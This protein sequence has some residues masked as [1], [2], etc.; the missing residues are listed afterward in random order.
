[1]LQA[2]SGLPLEVTTGDS[3]SSVVAVVRGTAPHDGERPVVLLR[4]DMD[5]LPVAEEVDVEYASERTGLMHACGHDLHVAALVGAARVLCELRDSLVGDVVLMFQ[6]G[7]EGPGGALPML[8][9]GLLTAAGPRVS[10]AYAVHV[11]AADHPGAC[12]GG[13]RGR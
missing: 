12:G 5:A 4:G 10:A 2:L 13:G 3:L 1:M 11:V 7:E 8:E 6:P 9:E